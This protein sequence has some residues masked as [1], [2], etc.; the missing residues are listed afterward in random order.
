MPSRFAR[1]RSQSSRRPIIIVAV[2]AMCAVSSPAASRRR[3]PRSMA[4]AIASTWGTQKLTVTLR[5]A[6][7]NVASSTEAMPAD[8][9]GNFTCM[10]GPSCASSTACTSIAARSLCKDGSVCTESRPHVRSFASKTGS[11]SSAPRAPISVYSCQAMDRSLSPARART[12]SPARG[13]HRSASSRS[14]E[15]QMT[16]LLVAPVAPRSMAYARSADAHES[17]K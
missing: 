4:S 17:L 7:W 14:T 9:A 13:S 16:G 1:T 5:F 12:I 11:I 6:P 15:R 2:G 8:V 3:R 10:L